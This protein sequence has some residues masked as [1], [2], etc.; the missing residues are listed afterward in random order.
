MFLNSI[1]AR[2]AD[3]WD[4]VPVHRDEHQVWFAVLPSHLIHGEKLLARLQLH[5]HD[6]VT[7][8]TVRVR[9][10]PLSAVVAGARCGHRSSSLTSCTLAL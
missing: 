4:L 1:D 10:L 2:L 8:L 7:R 3:S 5:L 6:D 9:L